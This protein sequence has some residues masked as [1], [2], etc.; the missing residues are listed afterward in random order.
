MSA[1]KSMHTHQIK[2]DKKNCHLPFPTSQTFCGLPSVLL[3]Y[4]GS[5]FRGQKNFKITL[6]LQDEGLKIFTLLQAHAL[7]P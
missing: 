5:L 4:L 3:M 6:V 7:V 2:Y 1:Y